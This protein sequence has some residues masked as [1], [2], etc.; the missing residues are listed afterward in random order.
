MK[1]FKV[2]DKV[3]YT[4]MDGQICFEGIVTVIGKTVCTVIITK[5]YHDMYPVTDVDFWETKTLTKLPSKHEVY[6]NAVKRIG[7]DH[8]L[9]VLLGELGELTQQTSRIVRSKSDVV[10][11]GLIE[12]IA[13]VEELLT[14]VKISLGIEDKVDVVRSVRYESLED[15]VELWGMQ[16]EN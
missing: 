8:V 3:K 14:E 15:F 9:V 1:A 6:E 7:I 5:S 12:A 16:D 4:R 11:V 2:G 10:L 13:D